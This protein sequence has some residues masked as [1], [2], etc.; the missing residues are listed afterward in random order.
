[1]SYAFNFGLPGLYQA[2]PVELQQKLD[3][4]GEVK[5][6][7]HGEHMQS[8]GDKTQGFSVIKAG[9]VCFGKYDEDGRFIAIATFGVGQCY[10]EFTLF[11]GL[12]RTHDGIAVG[13]T[14]VSHISKARFD[15]LMVSEPTL[16][17]AIISSLTLQLHSVLEYTDDLRRYPLKYRLGKALLQMRSPAGDIGLERIKITQSQLAD[18]MGVSRVAV[19]QV[20]A[21][22]RDHGFVETIYGGFRIPDRAVFKSWLTAFDRLEPV[23]LM[24]P[25]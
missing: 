4:E 20:L 25:N 14:A 23:A 17:S 16:A 9:A 19:A 24:Y 13:D 21:A 11:A 8:R 7:Q 1:V 5:R 12:P 3:G 15:R 6:Y 22:Y 10:G 2:L 18:L